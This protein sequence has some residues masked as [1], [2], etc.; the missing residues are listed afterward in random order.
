MRRCASLGYVLLALLASCESVPD[1]LRI[2][3]DG[4]SI[5]I[6]KKPPAPEEP[7]AEPR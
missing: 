4:R 2:E 5:E 7:S 6:K 1:D 3:A